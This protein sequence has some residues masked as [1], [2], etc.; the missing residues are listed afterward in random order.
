MRGTRLQNTSNNI[1]VA[2]KYC[3]DDLRRVALHTAT[4]VFFAAST[5][6]GYEVGD[7]PPFMLAVGGAGLVAAATNGVR[8]AQSLRRKVR[9]LAAYRPG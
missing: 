3:Q 9:R 1:L 7:L 2:W 5:I 8:V 4:S 6:K